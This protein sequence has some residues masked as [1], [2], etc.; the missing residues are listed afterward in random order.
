VELISVFV[1]TEDPRGSDWRWLGG[2]VFCSSALPHSSSG[3]YREQERRI[4]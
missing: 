3:Y 4:L 2:F 1:I